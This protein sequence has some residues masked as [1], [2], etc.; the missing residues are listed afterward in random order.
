MS[1]NSDSDTEIYVPIN[2]TKKHRSENRKSVKGNYQEPTV[3]TTSSNTSQPAKD[4][5]MIVDSQGDDSDCLL[6]PEVGNVLKQHAL[7]LENSKGRSSQSSHG[8][9]GNEPI[10]VHVDTIKPAEAIQGPK[11]AATQLKEVP[12]ARVS[13]A[14]ARTTTTP[15]PFVPLDSASIRRGFQEGGASSKKE[16]LKKGTYII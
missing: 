12:K 8:H 7:A 2:H 1:T 11:R 10:T 4:S 6:E 14:S 15:R 5:E 9:G 3:T 16:D 13:F